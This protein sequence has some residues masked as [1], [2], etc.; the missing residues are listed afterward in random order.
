[1]HN[2]RERKIRRWLTVI[3]LILCCVSCGISRF[4]GSPRYYLDLI[5]ASNLALLVIYQF[6]DD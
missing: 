2:E 4:S 1:M 5:A 3:T 6:A